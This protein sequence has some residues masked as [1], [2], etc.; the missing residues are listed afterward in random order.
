MMRQIPLLFHEDARALQA[1]SMEQ[2][3][4][5]T[6]ASYVLGVE[7]LQYLMVW[8]FAERLRGLTPEQARSQFQLRRRSSLVEKIEELGANLSCLQ[9]FQL[10]GNQSTPPA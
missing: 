5:L 9:L 7:P 2:L 10:G 6:H 1:I 4:G 8:A 3:L